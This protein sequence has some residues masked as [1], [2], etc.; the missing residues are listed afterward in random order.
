METSERPAGFREGGEELKKDIIKT[1]KSFFRFVK[2]YP[3]LFVALIGIIA[4]GVVYFW[5]DTEGKKRTAAVEKKAAAQLLENNEEMLKLLTKPLIWSIRSEMLRGNLEQVDI[6]ITDLVREKNF[7][8]ICLVGPNGDILVSTDKK[9]EGNPATGIV[10]ATVINTDSV[11]VNRK[12][13]EMLIVASPVMGYDKRLGTIVFEYAPAK[14]TLATRSQPT[15]D[16]SAG[17]VN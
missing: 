4:V 7:Q 1:K 14:V 6:F 13:N 8:Y 11:I 3:A 9:L 17:L 15:K 2:K 10:D 16:S 5:K 12:E